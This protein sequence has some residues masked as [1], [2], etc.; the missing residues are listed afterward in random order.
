MVINSNQSLEEKFSVII[1]E[2]GHLYC[3]HQGAYKGARWLDRSDEVYRGDPDKSHALREFEAECT[4]WLVCE[5]MNIHNSAA[6]YLSTYLDEKEEVPPISLEAIIKS[7]DKIETLIRDHKGPGK[8]LIPDE[9]WF[10]E[11]ENKRLGRI[12]GGSI[13]LP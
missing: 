4:A 10:K 3:G 6:A 8:D 5:R 2:L 7:V 13:R 11:R 12:I 9:L 1:H